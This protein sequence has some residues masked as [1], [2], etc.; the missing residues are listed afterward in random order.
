[1]KAASV[2]YPKIKFIDILTAEIT[3]ILT[4]P[5]IVLCILTTLIINVGLAVLDAS[6]LIF[7]TGA[8]STAATISDFSSLM[9]APIYAFLVF[10]VYAASSEYRGGQ[11]R[12]TLVAT[13]NRNN[14]M[15]A[16]IAAVSLTIL[17]S[18]LIT[19]IPSR[20]I[21]HIFANTSIN[22]LLFDLF[23]WTAVYFFMALIAFGLA[24]ITRSTIVPLSI[25][26]II[27]IFIGTGIIQ[28]PE[29]L[30]FLPDQASMSLLGTPAYE[31]TELPPLIA[32]ITLICWSI[33]FLGSYWV[34]FNK[35][36]S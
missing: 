23:R 6:G 8:D 19:I 9:F 24:G 20:L 11:H 16:K 13:P 1:M 22:Y 36:D 5:T 33:L 31:V 17:G 4:H 21:T 27:P 30:R 18:I 26:I 14:L 29:G 15:K 2:S 7:Y 10:P 35:S 3:K 34:I 28:W 25:L 12:M 32:L